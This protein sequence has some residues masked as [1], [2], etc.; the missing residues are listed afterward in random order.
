MVV[1]A[2]A[3]TWLRSRTWEQAW[4]MGLVGSILLTLCSFAVG[5][6]RHRG[7]VMQ[8]LGLSSLTFG[9]M[10]GIFA[11]LLWIA[12]A[13]LVLSWA[14]AGGFILRRG[15]QLTRKMWLAWIGP[16]IF[17]APLMSRDIYS[18]LM[19]GTLAR[20]GLDAYR[21][22]AAANPGP[23]LFEVSADWR[24]TTTPYGPAHLWLGKAITSITG[25]NITAGLVAFKV[26]T[27][28]AFAVLVW[29]VS[30]LAKQF[31][32]RPS[33][34]VWLGV[35]NPLVVIHLIG[36]LHTES[37]MMALVVV[38][39]LTSLRMRPVAGLL[40]GSALIAVGVA[41]KATAAI[42]LP[43][44]VW[45]VVYQ[46]AGPSEDS[47]WKDSWRRF[48]TLIWTG[49]VSVATVVAVMFAITWGSGQTWGWIQ[50][51]SG[52]TKVINPL[53]LPSFIASTLEPFISQIDDDITFN[54]IVGLVRP[55]S[56]V[57]MMLGLVIVWWLFRHDPQRAILGATV[58]YAVTC[59]FNAVTLPWYYVAPLVL[60]GACVR[61]R[62]AIFAIAWLSATMCFM[63]DGGGNN[64]LYELW[65]VLL[66]GV[67][68]WFVL[69][70]TLG[71][72]PGM[73]P[74][75]ADDWVTEA[76]AQRSGQPDSSRS[77]HGVK[78]APSPARV[79]APLAPSGHAAH[80]PVVPA[81]NHLR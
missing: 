46:I 61:N 41:L 2:T 75:E 40:A 63:F 72:A 18:Y 79:D 5:A 66:I 42:A 30:Q 6:T 53:A 45:I 4:R 39:L 31:D 36:G 71:F 12:L 80:Q 55:W 24:N 32:V 9:H 51:M 65:W 16:L 35:T 20:D 78:T 13:L 76:G 28:V 48:G 10:S 77:G 54:V 67:I 1:L 15:Y 52:N 68:Q 50:A 22:G 59:V 43:F 81:E 57:A 47:W 64:R 27:V 69:R 73:K 19:Q 34:A 58:G 29:A 8:V 62:R 26:L 14:I 11:V 23:L 21:V 25:D 37:M 60:V 49:L 44:L 38:G 33:V 3:N 17:S 7:G 74:G 56:M 70:A